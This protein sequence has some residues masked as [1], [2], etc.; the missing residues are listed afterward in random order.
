MS[1]EAARFARSL[2][3]LASSTRVAYER[4][5]R[6]FA[7]WARDEGVLGPDAVDRQVLRRYLVDL[8]GRDLAAASVRRRIAVLRRYFGWMVGR[9]LIDCDPTVGISVPRGE[10]R[11]PRVLNADELHVLIDEPCETTRSSNC[12]MGPGSGCRSCVV[13]TSATSICR[14]AELSCGARGRSNVLCP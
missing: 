2:S 8:H 7:Q 9:G 6:A 3:G 4:D 5:L 10:R 14:G 13:W 12:C 1:W 11:L